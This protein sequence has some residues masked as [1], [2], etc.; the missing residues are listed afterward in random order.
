MPCSTERIGRPIRAS[1]AT[2]CAFAATS[3]MPQPA[4]SPHTAGTSVANDGANAAPVSPA[5]ASTSPSAVGARLPLRAESQP[6]TGKNSVAVNVTMKRMSPS[7]PLSR[8]SRCVSAGRRAA[9]V[10]SSAPKAT[11]ATASAACAGALLLDALDDAGNRLAE[12]D[13]H[14]GDAV[15]GIAPLE[16]GDERRCDAGSG[17]AERMAEGDA[18]AVRVHVA[19]LIALLQAR[20]G[21]ELEHDGRERLVHLDHVDVVPFEPRLRERALARVG[22]S[23][24]HQV[25]VDSG[26]P[27]AE[28][29][30]A[31]L[32]PEL[33]CFLLGR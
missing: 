10:P 21:E 15:P 6:A 9:H 28:E 29:A 18:A 1:S 4:P 7:R 2:P 30:R 26:D 22:I 32:E 23:V 12:A 8:L 16:L 5:P 13:A 20:V 31:W 14:R 33:G 24:Q 19:G 3:A 11:N 27:E 25:R 17:R